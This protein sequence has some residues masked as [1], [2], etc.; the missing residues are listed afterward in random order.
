MSDRSTVHTTFTLERT[1]PAPPTRVFQAWADPEVKARW[2]AGN[3][4]DY[5]LD[6]RPGGTERKS[7]CGATPPFDPARPLIHPS[8]PAVGTRQYQ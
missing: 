6:F 5:E 1:Y 2:F 3:P 4:E 8:H 7:T